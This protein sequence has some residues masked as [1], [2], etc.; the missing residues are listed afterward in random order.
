ML[1]SL[2]PQCKPVETLHD[3]YRRIG[4]GAQLGPKLLPKGLTW[5]QV[6]PCWSKWF[7]AL[8]EVDPKVAA[9]S[10]EG[11]AFGGCWADLRNV[12]IAT[13]PCTSWGGVDPENGHP[14]EAVP[15]SKGSLELIAPKLSR[16]GISVRTD[17]QHENNYVVL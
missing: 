10:D 16:L 9:M 5:G 2:A 7:G 13:V 8:L 17:F 12:Q 11:G 3:E 6:S 14:A 15:V 1:H 4:C